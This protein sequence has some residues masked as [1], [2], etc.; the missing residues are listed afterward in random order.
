M[1]FPEFISNNLQLSLTESLPEL[2]QRKPSDVVKWF[3]NGGRDRVTSFI[4]EVNY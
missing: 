3:N 4:E 1:R 2:S